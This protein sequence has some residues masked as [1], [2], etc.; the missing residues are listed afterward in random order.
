MAAR[1]APMP[2]SRR[3]RSCAAVRLSRGLSWSSRW[4][5]NLDPKVNRLEREH[6]SAFYA[7]TR[8][9]PHGG[10]HPALG[11]AGEAGF[12]GLAVVVRG[13]RFCG[14][15]CTILEAVDVDDGA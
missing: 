1:S 3:A 12:C 10:R 11:A 5:R 13:D 15:G 9:A 8:S 4:Q 7:C 14:E 6:F 2:Y